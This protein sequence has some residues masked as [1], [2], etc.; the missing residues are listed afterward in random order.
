V[1]PE[2]GPSAEVSGDWATAGAN[3]VEV[4]I[5]VFR[6][7]GTLAFERRFEWRSPVAGGES[8][9]DMKQRGRSVPPPE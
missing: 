1:L 4:L 2:I 6:P 3:G 8:I 9:G 5:K 7:T